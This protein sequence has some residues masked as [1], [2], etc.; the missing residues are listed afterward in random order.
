MGI[1]RPTRPPLQL[2]QLD[3]VSP[4]QSDLGVDFCALVQ[5]LFLLFL[6]S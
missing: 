6:H 2:G 1:L 3:R 4:Y 5:K